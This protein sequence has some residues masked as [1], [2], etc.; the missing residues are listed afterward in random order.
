VKRLLG[1][2]A[3][4]AGTYAAF[5][6]RAILQWGAT[7]DETAGPAPGDGV[8]ASPVSVSTMATSY[9]APPE[10]IWPWL[11]Q[12]GTGRAGW[13]SWDL[14]DNYGRPSAEEILPGHQ[15]IAVGDLLPASRSGTR[16]FEVV[17]LSPQRHLVLR[18]RWGVG[19]VIDSTWSLD[20]RPS[21][22]GGTRLV[23][24]ARTA[25]RPRS[26]I[27]LMELGIHEPGHLLMQVRQ[28]RGLRVRVDR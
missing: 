12:M 22:G 26:L 4:G 25:G 14:V 8:I 17:A 24:R 11:V 3:I 15:S 18:A 10:A 27:R 21:A 2:V 13:Y 16:A 19:V 6:R 28:F 23:V 9:A 1:L 5:G 7:P 20:L